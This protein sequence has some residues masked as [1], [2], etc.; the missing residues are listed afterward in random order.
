MLYRWDGVKEERAEE[1]HDASLLEDVDVL[2]IGGEVSHALDEGNA[3]L[4]V[5]L[6]HPK[7]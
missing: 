7:H 4:L 2:G 6:K 1:T 5:R 3:G